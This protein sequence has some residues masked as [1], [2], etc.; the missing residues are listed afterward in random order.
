MDC[1]VCLSEKSPS[2]SHILR[3][4]GTSE[5]ELRTKLE[6]FRFRLRRWTGGIDLLFEREE[7]LVKA[8]NCIGN[9]VYSQGEPMEKVVGDLLKK[10]GFTLSVAESCT[11]GLISARLVNIPGSSE[12][13]LGGVVVYS[14]ELKRKLLGVK[15]ETLEKFGAVSSQTCG[16]MLVGL[17]E[18]FGSDSGIAVTGIAG[19]GGSERKPEGLTYIGV[20]LK[21]EEVIEENLFEGS[22]NEKRLKASQRSFEILRKM[23]LKEEE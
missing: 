14:N 10:R 17:R 7:D 16:E 4:S 18:R 13:F 23:L 5:D 15:E 8:K 1:E 9:Y 6:G 22:R 20:Y 11:G 3:T 19:P 21:D 12:Y 2:E